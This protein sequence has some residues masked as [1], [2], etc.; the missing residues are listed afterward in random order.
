MR[1]IG[2]SG[3]SVRD[4]ASPARF[5]ART[6][7][8]EWEE[9]GET[10]DLIPFYEFAAPGDMVEGQLCGTRK[11]RDRDRYV[12]EDVH[13][14]RWLLPDHAN[15]MKRLADVA[16]GDL[17]RITYEGESTFESRTY[18]QVTAKQYRVQ[19]RRSRTSAHTAAPR[20]SMTDR[21][22]DPEG[23]DDVSF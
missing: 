22:R 6:Q 8:D 13:G 14:K 9:V 17:L 11:V 2:K 4:F 15:L 19:R 21:R 1:P 7:D 23:D 18:G 12:L 20:S 10:S 16:T 5:E 3:G